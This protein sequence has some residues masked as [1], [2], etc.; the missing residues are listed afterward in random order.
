MKDMTDSEDAENGVVKGIV[1]NYVQPGCKKGAGIERDYNLTVNLNC[2]PK[3]VTTYTSGQ[4]V[5]GD[6]C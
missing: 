2:V 1:M 5:N 6:E 3:Q 4:F